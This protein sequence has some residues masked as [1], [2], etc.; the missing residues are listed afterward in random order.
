MNLELEI[1]NY[2]GL[3]PNS[4]QKEIATACGV[5]VYDA[6]FLGAMMDLHDLQL[7]VNVAVPNPE[8]ETEFL[9]K[10]WLTS[11]GK[12]VIM[13]AQKQERRNQDGEDYSE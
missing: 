10:W 11:K 3:H 6:L 2:V 12:N 7:M 9:Y 8:K 4:T 1:L 5:G 13:E